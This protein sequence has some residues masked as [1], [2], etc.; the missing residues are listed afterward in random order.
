MATQYPK[1]SQNPSMAEITQVINELSRTLTQ[2]DT[3][4][5]SPYQAYGRVSIATQADSPYQM[6]TDDGVI[7]VD[8]SGGAVDV[9]LR[10]ANENGQNVA[11]RVTVKKI[12]GT[13]VVTVYS[14]QPELIDG[15]ANI[16]IS[17]MY[18][19]FEFTSDGYNWF[20]I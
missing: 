15:A 18:N 13:G 2:R 6:K 5:L 10:R 16:A 8:A 4:P 17:T 12:A 19:S 1:L 3:V 9:Y 11:R 14:Q 20:I 7:L